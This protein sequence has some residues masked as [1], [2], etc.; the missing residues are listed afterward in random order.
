MSSS[1][2]GAPLDGAVIL[3]ISRS[4]LTTSLLLATLLAFDV[5]DVATG[6]LDVLGELFVD[7]GFGLGIGLIVR[8]EAVLPRGAALLVVAFVVVGGHLG[9]SWWG[10]Q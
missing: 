1:V 2:S 3:T 7:L 4:I 10:M 6:L 9:R 8:R 5:L